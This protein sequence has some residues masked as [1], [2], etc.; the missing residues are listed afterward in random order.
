MNNKKL[1][2]F[3]D[4]D[5][6]LIDRF[7]N[8][9]AYEFIKFLNENDSIDIIWSTCWFRTLSPLQRAHL[10]EKASDIKIDYK[11]HY[12]RRM[13]E[14]FFELKEKELNEDNKQRDLF[15]N[16]LKKLFKKAKYLRWFSSKTMDLL[17]YIDKFD[18]FIFV[19]DGLLKE[20]IEYLYNMNYDLNK[21]Y[22]E[23]NLEKENRNLLA[24]KKF[25]EERIQNE[26]N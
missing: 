15:Y 9:D 26:N 8:K 10:L 1:T 3:L 25:I 16:E 6:V 17:K 12:S 20:E 4:V 5:G 19:E 2:I 23:I 7:W 22:F 13:F 14:I 24:C 21:V 11:K 18:D